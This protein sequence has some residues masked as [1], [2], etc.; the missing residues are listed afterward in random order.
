[1]KT[2]QTWMR[3]LVLSAFFVSTLVLVIGTAQF[4]NSPDEQANFFFAQ[5]FAQTG[6]L[7]VQEPVNEIL[8]G[9]LHPRSM[10][11]I[12]E[13]IVPVTFVGFP[14]LA[15]ILAGV[16]GGYG[17]QLLT[18]VLAV[19]AL[20]AWH[21]TVRTVFDDER[22][23]DIAALFLMIHPVFW[24]YTARTMMHNVAFVSFLLFAAWAL[25]TKPFARG[26]M[27]A[28]V[29]GVF[30]GLAL[31]LRTSEGLW[32]L[33]LVA[34]YF[35]FHERA[36][37]WQAG[38]GWLVGCFLALTPFFALNTSL[39]G[40]PLTTGYTYTSDVAVEEVV[41][42]EEVHE[43][44]PG[45]LAYVFPFGIHERNIL[46]NVW[47]Y[48]FKLYWWMSGL[49]VIG[50]WFLWQRQ[51]GKTWIA[52]TGLLA[53]WLAVV[54][55]SW[56]IYDNPDPTVISLANS[57]TRYWLPLFT[58]ASV[59]S[60]AVV[61][62]LPR[63]VQGVVIVTVMA[64]SGW[65]TFVAPDGLLPIRAALAENQEKQ[66]MILAHTPDNAIVIV[67]YA[68]KYV[69]PHRRVVVPLRSEQTYAELSTLAQTAPLYYFGI[70]LPPEDIAHLQDV[71]LSPQNLTIE[72]VQTID[73]ETL[74]EIRIAE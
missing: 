1:V 67:D 40:S 56:M 3:G 15:G 63:L 61:V 24:H 57:H 51:N 11:A 18:P 19:L 70:T 23:A 46:E 38:L 42:V 31:S 34:A 2:W 64:L 36:Q 32:V 60:A 22:L 20:I 68:D 27:N 54:Y 55:G 9:L 48:G 17:A 65:L 4:M 72:V 10:L 35:F 53:V 39:Y 49:A 30:T 50:I 59:M 7:F 44:L 29:G 62:R 25:L 71:R 26:W 58:L 5:T 14:L 6:G 43:A 52:V 73:H 69:F 45:M 37:R 8:G 12:G 66:E 41:P 21:K 47:H 16:F 13:M 28:L 33:G 74:Y